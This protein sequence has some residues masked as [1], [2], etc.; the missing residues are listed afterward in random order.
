MYIFIA[1]TTQPRSRSLEP[2][3]YTPRG[4]INSNWPGVFIKNW[5]CYPRPHLPPPRGCY[6]VS[7]LPSDGGPVEL[8]PGNFLRS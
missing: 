1:P 8:P 5:G 6:M 4:V 2:S 3:L 7:P